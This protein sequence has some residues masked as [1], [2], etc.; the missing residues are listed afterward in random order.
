MKIRILTLTALLST[1]TALNAYAVATGLYTGLMLGSA[2]NSGGTQQAQTA[3]GT[4]P[5]TPKSTQFGSRIY[6]GYKFSRYAGTEMGLS[7]YS[8][9]NYN[10][11]GVQTCS[12]TNVRIRDFDLVA[13]GEYDFASVDVYGKAGAAFAYQTVSGGLSGNGVNGACGTTQYTSK[14]KPTVSL[15]ASYDLNQSWVTD[16]SWNRI[17]MGGPAGNVDLYALGIAYHFV[18]IYCGQFLCN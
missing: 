14:V 18:N 8:S 7:Y 16:L 2:T 9:I 11:K 1:I 15:G 12:G 10:T 13:K 17:M 5:A 3:T 6:L 4:T